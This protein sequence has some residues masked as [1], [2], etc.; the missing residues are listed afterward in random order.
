M[1]EINE[2]IQN[3]PLTKEQAKKQFVEKTKELGIKHALL[4]MRLGK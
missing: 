4:L 1:K 2:Q 3:N